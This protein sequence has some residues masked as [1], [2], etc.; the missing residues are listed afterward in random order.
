MLWMHSNTTFDG[1]TLN[2]HYL[3][4]IRIQLDNAMPIHTEQCKTMC[5]QQVEYCWSKGRVYSF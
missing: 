5:T 2:E 4:R 3:K 1:V